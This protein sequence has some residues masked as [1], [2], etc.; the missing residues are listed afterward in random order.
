M[1]RTNGN[2]RL[3]VIAGLL[4]GAA[5]ALLVSPFASTSPDGLERV[6]EDEGFADAA[7]EHR[8]G[9]SPLADYAVRGVDDERV[10]TGAAG[11]IG[12]LLTFGLA[13]GV[14][15]AVRVLRDRRAPA[16]APRA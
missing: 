12:V 15:A 4:V 10:S 14:V 8:L 5:L 1:K 3:F 11:V 16:E 9:D 6:A 7:D 2:V 13:T